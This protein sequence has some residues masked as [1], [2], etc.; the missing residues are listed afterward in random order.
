MQPDR[1]V[2]ERAS[3]ADWSVA[4]VRETQA[5]GWG[6]DRSDAVVAV[7][8]NTGLIATLVIGVLVLLA[9]GLIV[10]IRSGS[11][12]STNSSAEPAN[13]TE[14]EATTATETADP[15]AEFEER[16]GSQTLDRLEPI[17]P[18]AV[19]RVRTRRPGDREERTETVDQLE[20]ELRRGVEDAIVNGDLDPSLTSRYGESYEIVNLP[21]RY[22]EVTLPPSNE[23]IH[24]TDLESVAGDALEHEAGVRTVEKTVSPLYD[25]CREIESYVEQ[26]EEAFATQYTA[27]ERTL[28]DI[29]ELTDRLEGSL[30]ERISE[31][32]LEG[33]HGE[34]DGVVEIERQLEAATRSLHRCAFDEATRT[35][36][37]ARRESDE[38][39]LT[40]DFL[41]GLVG[42]I[43]HG[44]AQIEIPDGVSVAF[45]TDLTSVVER[46]YDVTVELEGR[47]IIVDDHSE[48]VTGSDRTADSTVTSVSS[49]DSAS[50]TGQQ[51]ERIAPE[52]VADE[53]LFILR[54]LD[55]VGDSETVECQ[56]EQLPETVARPEVLSEL[57]TFCR[58][59]TDIVATVELQDG[60]PPGFL[61]LEF[62][63]Q[64]GASSGLKALRERF[65]DRYGG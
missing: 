16:I 23:T 44:S 33:R 45:I 46:A 38:L 6:I 24:I 28:E 20:R 29:R 63:D 27:L 1:W 30:G 47:T 12:A 65:T 26:R 4:T 31:F 48:S 36:R 42:T 5:T 21:S 58:R 15:K 40:V 62:V 8:G 49:D 59:Q 50:Q 7:L 22:R 11:A 55:S 51:R 53:L 25:H 39:L 19:E 57:A 2:A 61:E 54:E 14:T 41:G 43:E 64:F 34:I 37:D 3:I 18:E 32:V 52:S 35:L 60:A 13:Q 17:A 10:V 56:T 9:G